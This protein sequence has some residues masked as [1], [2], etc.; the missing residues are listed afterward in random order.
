MSK[1]VDIRTALDQVKSGNSVMIGGFA[2]CGTP[3]NLLAELEKRDVRHLTT[4]SEDFHNGVKRF[5]L[6][7]TPLLKKNM[8]DEII[9][10][11]FGHR[12]AQEKIDA[13]LIKLTLIPQ[14]TLAERI[15]AGGAG[16]G[17]F[18]T[19]VG[20]GTIVEE[21]KEKRVINGKEYL[22]ELP[23]RANVALLKC[24]TADPLGNAVFAYTAR[25]FN[26]VMATAADI[27]ILEC[28][29]LVNPGEIAPDAV[30][31]PGIFVDYVVH[32]GGGGADEG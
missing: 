5:D 31:L 7:L 26:C 11:F 13:G 4:I 25:N 9:V 29:N 27:V 12:E 3:L 22:L 30:H 8:I 32:C 15:R 21:G 19:P 24:H 1:L 23:L 20:V 18:F 2:C 28:E 14:G 17:G 16:L 10:S 6:G